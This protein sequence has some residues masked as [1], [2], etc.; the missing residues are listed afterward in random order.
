MQPVY[1]II[2]YI[3]FVDN[4][5]GAGARGPGARGPGARAIMAPLL[6]RHW[7]SGHTPYALCF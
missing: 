4:L 6:I 2:L 3:L 7:I 1:V 5:G